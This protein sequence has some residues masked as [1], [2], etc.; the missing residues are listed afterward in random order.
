MTLLLNRCAVEGEILT[1]VVPH[2][3]HVAL[4]QIWAFANQ[5]G[6]LSTP[7]HIHILDCE[8]C[9]NA[10]KVCL[11]EKSFGSVLKKLNRKDDRDKA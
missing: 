4:H 6:E 5:K 1:K 2:P 7:E 11:Q 9:R 10:V 8:E 3:S